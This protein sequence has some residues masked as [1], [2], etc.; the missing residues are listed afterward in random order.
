MSVPQILERLR[1]VGLKSAFNAYAGDL[2]QLSCVAATPREHEPRVDGEGPRGKGPVYLFQ[3][4]GGEVKF[5]SDALSRSAERRYPRD[6][7]LA[8]RAREIINKNFKPLP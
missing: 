6:E 7:V 5:K 1:E 2:T 3:W 8:A 4:K